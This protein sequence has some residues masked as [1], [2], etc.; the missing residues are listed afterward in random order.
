MVNGLIYGSLL[1]QR[2][3]YTTNIPLLYRSPIENTFVINCG[4]YASVL[5]EGRLQSPLHRVRLTERER[6]SLVYFQYPSF[7]SKI[8]AQ[9]LSSHQFSHLSL[10][11]NQSQDKSQE[12][13]EDEMCVGTF[14]DL[15]Y[16][17]WMQVQRRN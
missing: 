13:T 11:K 9:K 15:V 6:I 5:S 1:S 2:S 10:F 12:V 7:E 17:K 4:D 16:K 8:P 14:G 3:I